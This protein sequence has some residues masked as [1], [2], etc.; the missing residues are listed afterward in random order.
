[1]TSYFNS[2]DLNKFGFKNIG[3]NVSV[4]KNTTIIGLE[5]ISIGNNVRIDSGTIIAAK[6]GF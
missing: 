3:A 5:N 1:M 2:D 4:A 6:S